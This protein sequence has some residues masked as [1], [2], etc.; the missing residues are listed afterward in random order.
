MIR[1]FTPA[2]SEKLE[3]VPVLKLP[4]D[5]GGGVVQKLI[6]NKQLTTAEKNFILRKLT[7]GLGNHRY[8]KIIAS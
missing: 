1:R 6:K 5:C 8:E 7:Y 2:N 4:H 3:K